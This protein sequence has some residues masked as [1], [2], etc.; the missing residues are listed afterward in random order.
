MENINNNDSPKNYK[1]IMVSSTFSD[2]VEH[3]KIVFEMIPKYGFFPNVMENDSA[4]TDEDV[5]DSSLNMVRDS[6]VY[7]GIITHK[8]GKIYKDVRNPDELSLTELEFNE[9]VRLG[10]PILLFIMGEEYDNLKRRDIESDALK[11]KK[12]E[13]FRERAKKMSDESEVTRVYAEFNN[14]VE[15]TKKVQQSLASVQKKFSGNSEETKPVINEKTP[16]F[17]AVSPY[18]G[19]HRFIGRK[20][21]LKRLDEWAVEENSNPVFLLDAMGGMGKSMIAWE[22]T[23]N[24]CSNIRTDWAGKFWYSF[25]EQGASLRLFCIHALSYMTN[26]TESVFAKKSTK[27]LYDELLS[28]LKAQPWLLVLDGLERILVCY[29]RHDAPHIPEILIEEGKKDALRD[30]CQSIVP[31]DDDMLRN[32]VS[33][34]PSKMLITSRLRPKAFVNVSEGLIPGI[35][36][37]MLRGLN[38]DDALDFFQYCKI[39]GNPETIKKFLKSQCDNHP[40]VIGALAGVINQYIPDRG[41]FDSWYQDKDEVSKLNLGE[42]ELRQKQHHILHYSIEILSENSKEILSYLSFFYDSITYDTFYNFYKETKGIDDDSVLRKLIKTALIDLERRGL[43]QSGS[44][45]YDL[46]PV[47]RSITFET[48]TE[49]KKKEAGHKY[50]DYFNKN[51]NIDYTE[52]ADTQEI[53]NEINVV[54]TFFKINEPE[55]IYTISNFFGLLKCLRRLEAHRQVVELTEPFWENNENTEELP[56]SFLINVYS[57]Y[58]PSV[59]WINPNKDH[60][61]NFV[62]K[63][64]KN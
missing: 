12:L 40:L 48:L 38:N 60:I 33:A 52:V 5:I 51:S 39:K 16:P 41:N 4:K 17:K 49:H 8:Y 55:K 47:V 32:L 23:K 3:R 20:D 27:E 14:T 53:K 15:F 37:Y 11:M 25:Y 62:E 22:W 57:W 63:I 10:R 1:G 21:E 36:P 44:K 19:S 54:Y 31:T 58:I 50:T 43:V 30:P 9:A 35:E 56:V 6:A 18:I 2:M 26:Q 59:I 28:Q 24:H 45:N 64:D 46:H 61:I 29:H 13:E 7:M 34:S 42:L